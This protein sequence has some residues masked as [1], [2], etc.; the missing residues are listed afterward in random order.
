[1]REIEASAAGSDGLVCFTRLYLQVT[2]SVDVGLT[3]FA[4]PGYLGTLD[5]TFAGLFFDAVDAAAAESATMPRAWAPLFEA[6][7]RRGIAPLQFAVAGMNAHINRDLPVALARTWTGLGAEPADG[8][9]EHADFLR[10]NT[11]L[12]AVEAKVKASYMNGWLARL[13]RFVHR[14]DRV[15][16]VLMMWNVERARDAAW[17]NGRAL[18]ALRGEPELAR[19]FL[20]TL[21]RTV[22][23]AGRGLLLPS[24]SRLRRLARLLD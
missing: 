20:D 2:E 19:D 10:V 16:D 18:W 15:D 3:T 23:L 13:D 14:L 6:R 8:S 24:E 5:V 1:M 22:G 4:A 21:D 12:A 7:S 11:L 17:T 9:A